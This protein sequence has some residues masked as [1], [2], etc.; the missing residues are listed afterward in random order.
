MPQN[1]STNIS[2]EGQTLQAVILPN[3]RRNG[4]HFEV[5]I[6]GFPRFWLRWGA[7]DRYEVVRP[8]GVHVPDGLVLVVSDAIE[9]K[10]GA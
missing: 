10:V 6:S 9:K 5:N 4:M 1:F 7:M 2:Y 3:L 8:A